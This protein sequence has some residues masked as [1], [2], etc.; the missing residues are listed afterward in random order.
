MSRLNTL[1]GRSLVAAWLLWTTA[2]AQTDMLASESR[3]CF[4]ID[5]CGGSRVCFLGACVEPGYSLSEIYAELQPPNSSPWLAQTTPEPLLLSEGFASLQLQP[6]VTV[7]G[8]F[9]TEDVLLAGTVWAR[10]DTPIREVT[11]QAAVAD[12]RFELNVVA[13]TYSLRF[14]PQSGETTVRQ[15]PLA[16]GRRQLSSEARIEIEYPPQRDWLQVSGDVRWAE[17]VNTGITGALV[18]VT[19][20]GPS[21]SAWRSSTAQT[22]QGRFEVVLPPGAER[23]DLTIQPGNNPEVPELTVEDVPVAESTESTYELSPVDFGVAPPRALAAVVQTAD[24]G[25]P[26]EGATV[27]FAGQ[28]GVGE[29]RADHRVSGSTD[30]AGRIVGV[31]TERVRLLAPGEYTVT[32]APRP[33]SPYALQTESIQLQKDAPPPEPL[34]FSLKRKAT[35]SGTVR[36]ADGQPVVDAKISAKLRGSDVTRELK[37][38]TGADGSYAIDVAPRRPGFEATYEVWVEPQRTDGLPRHRELVKMQSGDTQHDI[39]LHPATFVFGSVQTPGGEPAADVLLA[40]YSLDLGTQ[41]EPL[42]VGVGQTNSNG[43]F[44]VPVPTPRGEL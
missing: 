31:A 3:E 20:R 1:C 10:R 24:T 12:N 35:L 4:N 13:G 41:A 18:W 9:A 21:G 40:F 19:G 43:E 15:P 27:T 26:L 33:S 25:A 7:A 30:A 17:P 39:R 14:E 6:A 8:R 29:R 36:S 44:V 28:V 22:Q 34:T 16:M 38:S 23:F 32:I 2:C 42:L 5:D 11:R 37:T